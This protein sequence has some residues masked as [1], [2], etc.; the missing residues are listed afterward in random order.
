MVRRTITEVGQNRH[1]QHVKLEST[2]IHNVQETREYNWG[3]LANFDDTIK[4][5]P[6]GRSV[7][8]YLELTVKKEGENNLLRI[9]FK[10]TGL[11]AGAE[12]PSP[13]SHSCSIFTLK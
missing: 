6:R 11:Q 13:F 2:T 3:L 12:I 1:G 10:M 5:T 7:Q 8:V 4:L 9:Y